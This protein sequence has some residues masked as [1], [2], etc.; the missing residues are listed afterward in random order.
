[1]NGFIGYLI[2]QILPLLVVCTWTGYLAFVVVNPRRLQTKMAK[3]KEGTQAYELYRKTYNKRSLGTWVC[4][5]LFFL[6]S[7][8]FDIYRATHV[9]PIW[10]MCLALLFTLALAFVGLYLTF[11]K[12]KK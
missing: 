5:S 3:Y 12:P 2:F 7:V 10:V 1:M 8:A 6:F 9:P 4:L 11:G